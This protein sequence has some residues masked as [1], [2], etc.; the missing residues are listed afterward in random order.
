MIEHCVKN[1]HFTQFAIYSGGCHP[2]FTVNNLNAVGD[3]AARKSLPVFLEK[4]LIEFQS[5]LDTDPSAN[6]VQN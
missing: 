1:L 6:P 5:N 2:C 4:V 3:E